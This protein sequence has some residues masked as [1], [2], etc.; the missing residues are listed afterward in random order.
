MKAI[1]ELSYKGSIFE[2]V[3]QQ[4]TEA[5]NKDIATPTPMRYKLKV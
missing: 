5:Q 1:I 4:L 3:K 2:A